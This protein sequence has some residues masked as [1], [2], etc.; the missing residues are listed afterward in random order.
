MKIS[1]NIKS[2]FQNSF[3]IFLS[4]IIIPA[5]FFILTVVIARRLGAYALGNCAFVLTLFYVFELICCLGMDNLVIREVA[6]DNQIAEKFLSSGVIIGFFS[7]FV[8][9]FLMVGITFIGQYPLLTK[10]LIFIIGVGLFPGFINYLA[11]SIFIGLE[12]SKYLFFGVLIKAIGILLFSLFFVLIGWKLYGVMLAIV[13]GYILSAVFLIGCFLREKIKIDK[14][15]DKEFIKKF[16]DV[17]ST[18][19]LINIL[20]S[21]FYAVDIIIISKIVSIE[22]VGIYSIAKRAVRMGFVFVFSIVTALFPIISKT[23]FS[24]RNDFRIIY[25]KSLRLIFLLSFGLT[26]ILILISA[27]FIL[28]VYGDAYSKAIQLFRILSCNIIFLSL[29]FLFSRFII[30]AGQQ[31]K[32]LLALGLSLGCLFILAPVFT[33]KWGI[34]GMA[35]ASLIAQI[36][37]CGIHYYILKQYVIVNLKE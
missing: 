30:S 9:Y 17:F 6:N 3:W 28:F 33:Y 37:L 25:G 5:C 26:M 21:I 13:I 27:P 32:D 24:K 7:A 22:D 19:F 29:S 10:K 35:Y 31:S 16:K 23:I 1:H 14:I 8:C 18:F 2:I 15:I 20:V 36:I 4:K 34:T 12:K 11:E